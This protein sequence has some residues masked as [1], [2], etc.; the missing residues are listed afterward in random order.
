M[1]FGAAIG[2]LL[3]FVTVYTRLTPHDEL[4]LIRAGNSAA[5]LA[6]GGTLIAF[7]LP[8]CS[9]LIHAVSILDFLVWAGVAFAVQIG[10]F[11][12]VRIFDTDLSARITRNEMAAGIVV[13]SASIAVGLVN[14]ACM[15][16]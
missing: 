10:T 14:A 13:A 5:A 2:V 1:Y 16:P 3:L 6:F 4:G 7:A 8:L 11:F 12:T 15:T 9:A